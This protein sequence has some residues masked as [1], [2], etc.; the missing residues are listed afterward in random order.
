MAHGYILVTGESM[1]ANIFLCIFCPGTITTQAESINS[2]FQL[3]LDWTDVYDTHSIEHRT[4]PGSHEN[5]SGQLILPQRLWLSV[6]VF[7]NSNPD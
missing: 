3:G 2:D 4:E 7:A 1:L 5:I 6:G